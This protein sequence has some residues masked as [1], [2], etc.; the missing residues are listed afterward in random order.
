MEKTDIF[1]D[2]IVVKSEDNFFFFWWLNAVSD[3]EL[4][5]RPEGEKKKRET[6]KDVIG[7]TGKIWV[8]LRI[9]Q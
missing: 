2:V 3:P 4:N 8:W 6:I 1:K 7:T 9:S 5:A